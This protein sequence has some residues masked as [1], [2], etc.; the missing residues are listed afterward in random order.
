MARKKKKPGQMGDYIGIRGGI[1]VMLK[2]ALT[3]EVLMHEKGFNA[4]LNGGRNEL[5]SRAYTTAS[6]TSYLIPC[7]IVG[8]GTTAA[9]VSDSG[10]LAYQTFKT[11]A[12]SGTTAGSGAT[13]P[14][15]ALTASWESTEL[16]GAGWA[17]SIREFALGFDLAGSTAN[18]GPHTPY[19]CRYVSGANISCTTTNQLLITYTLSF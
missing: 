5:M 3:G 19:L 9:A 8:S 17:Q 1:E 10:P 6:H 18:S 13:A 12:W 11:G 15:L 2:N 16:T 7:V 14:I 4:V